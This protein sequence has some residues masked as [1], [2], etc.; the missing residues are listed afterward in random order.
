MNNVKCKHEDLTWTSTVQNTR[1]QTPSP[2]LNSKP[3][4]IYTQPIQS[5]HTQTL[6]S[7]SPHAQKTHNAS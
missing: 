5:I 7:Q 6:K 2:L 1:N 3:P 4:D